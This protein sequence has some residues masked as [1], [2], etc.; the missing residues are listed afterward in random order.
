MNVLLVG[1]LALLLSL[2]G[3]Q[4]L[5]QERQFPQSP[6]ISPRLPQDPLKTVEDKQKRLAETARTTLSEAVRIAEKAI[7]GKA[8]EAVLDENHDQIVYRVTIVDTNKKV[9]SIQISAVD[10]KIVEPKK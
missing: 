8:V 2:S 4:G 5:A 9:H 6:G 7:P 1:L 10:G 3:Q